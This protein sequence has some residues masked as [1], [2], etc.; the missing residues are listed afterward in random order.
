MKFDLVVFFLPQEKVVNGGIISIFSLCKETRRL[1]GKRTETVACLM[2]GGTPFHT[3]DL[4]DNKEYIFDMDE[5][6]DLAK[7]HHEAL[8]HVPEYKAAQFYTLLKP[9]LPQLNHLKI[10]INIL[11]QNNEQMPVP[12]EL[13]DLFLLTS[14][15]TQTTAHVS[16]C[17][18]TTSDRYGIPTHLFSVHIDPK[19][20][21]FTPYRDKQDIIAYSL[22]DHPSKKAILR[23]IKEHLPTY[24]L[25]EIKG[26]RFEDY[27]KLISDAKFVITFGEG[28]DGY[29]IEPTFSGSISFAVY[30]ESFFPDTSYK[31]L[32]TIFASYEA[33]ETSIT[34]TIKALDEE[35]AYTKANNDLFEKLQKIYDAEAYRKNISE[36]Y[37]GNFDYL[38]QPQ[39]VMNLAR[40]A[41]TG[42]QAAL[43]GQVEQ[44][45]HLR[46]VIDDYI[47]VKKELETRTANLEEKLAKA[48]VF[49][50]YVHSLPGWKTFSRI[51]HVARRLR[52]K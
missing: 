2:P 5:L 13:A 17:T 35:R 19:N 22:D 38:P 7:N 26:L 1:L 24:E 33:M 29:L 21:H 52:R 36:F 30:N 43:E 37:H 16:Y 27:K 8:F 51:H 9:Y 42:K 45:A 47:T 10:S 4:F 25:K 31:K 18:Q 3:N 23:R 6:V 28:F 15:I 20:Y 32:P 39:S 48:T 49:I 34:N 40:E 41:I 12:A 44:V 11:N 50:E 14:S 46:K